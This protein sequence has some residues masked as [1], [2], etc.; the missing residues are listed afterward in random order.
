MIRR[1][2][3]AFMNPSH[4]DGQSGNSD[5]KESLSASVDKPQL[6]HTV[7]VLRGSE[8]RSK[9]H[10]LQIESIVDCPCL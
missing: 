7:E 8:D 5:A 9:L 1:K 4:S 10:A 3:D 2:E 6:A